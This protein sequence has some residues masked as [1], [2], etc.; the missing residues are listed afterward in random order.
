M[1]RFILTASLP[2]LAA[3]G[4][5]VDAGASPRPASVLL[6]AMDGLR[7][8]Q[9][10]AYQGGSGVTPNLD[11]LAREGLRYSDVATPAP[12]TAPAVAALLT[13]RYPTAP[14]CSSR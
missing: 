8:D 12:W 10:G 2:L 5:D 14:P 11:Q 7:V 3:C 6:V 4:G 13:G 9:V 1:P